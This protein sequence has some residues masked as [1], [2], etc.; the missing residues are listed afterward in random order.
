MS[1]SALPLAGIKVVEFAGL[2]PVPFAGLVLADFGAS[3]VRVDRHIRGGHQPV[4]Q[5]I[6]CRNKRSIAIN[7]KSPQGLD[8]VRRLIR[9]ADV[10]LDTFRPGVL[11]KLG[12]GPQTWLGEHGNKGENEKLV[13]ARIAGYDRHGPQ[14]HLAGHDINY[15]AMSGVLSLLPGT[16]EK[17]AFPLNLLSDFAGGGLTCALGIVMAL[18]ERS[19]SGRGQV[20]DADMVS[21]TRYLSTYPFFHHA[22]RS[23]LFASSDSKRQL[24]V[25]DAG[26]PFYNVYACS[27]RKAVTVG[28]LEPQFF[29]EFL[30]GFLRAV[31]KEWLA[32]EK[33]TPDLGVQ[34]RKTEWPVFKDF[35]ERGFKL[36][37]RDEWATVFDGTDACV[38]PVLTPHEAALVAAG[39]TVKSPLPDLSAEIPQSFLSNPAPK[40]SRTPAQPFAGPI[41]YLMPGEHTYEVLQEIGFDADEAGSLVREGAVSAPTDEPTK[42]KL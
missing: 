12:L 26:A 14:S 10:L 24:N 39:G 36:R 11:E 37:S 30:E 20:V 35:L 31:P 3:V 2:A 21:G 40:L 22:L 6:L 23:P 27:D 8:V 16:P 17:P 32:K 4:T 25:L 9:D 28:C 13:F 29:R 19:R 1:A 5:D 33:W 38:T 42:A 18:F 41:G 7:I 34:D 15:L